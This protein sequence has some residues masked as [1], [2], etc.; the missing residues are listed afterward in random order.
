M[1]QTMDYIQERKEEITI[2]RRGENGKVKR[3]LGS[4]KLEQP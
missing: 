2:E 4:P 1:K 3:S